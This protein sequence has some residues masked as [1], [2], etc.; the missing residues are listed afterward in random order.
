MKK[1]KLI[2]A[3]EAFKVSSKEVV[4]GYIVYDP[5]RKDANGVSWQRYHE[6]DDWNCEIGSGDLNLGQDPQ[7]WL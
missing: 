1:Q 6:Y 3:F 5:I 4:G 7:R 2:D